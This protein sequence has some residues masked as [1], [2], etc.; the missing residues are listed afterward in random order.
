MLQQVLLIFERQ[1]AHLLCGVYEVA[2][3]DVARK[4][5][6]VSPR[7]DRRWLS[8]SLEALEHL[9]AHDILVELIHV[10]NIRY[11]E[12]VGLL[13]LVVD[14]SRRCLG[15]SRIPTREGS[16]L[17]KPLLLQLQLLCIALALVSKIVPFFMLTLFKNSALSRLQTW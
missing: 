3:G 6:R 11:L 1:H 10:F 16:S 4:M 15:L 8:R 9:S 13:V 12:D 7:V 17:P 14:L 5:G 2:R